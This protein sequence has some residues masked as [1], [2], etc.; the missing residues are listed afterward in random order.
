[1]QT[2]LLRQAEFARQIGVSEG[3]VRRWIATGRVAYVRL[4]GGE[5]RI[6]SDEVQRILTVSYPGGSSV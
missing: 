3:T 2:M 1:M 5:R 4:P 6:V